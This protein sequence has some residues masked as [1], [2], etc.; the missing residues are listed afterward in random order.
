MGNPGTEAP[1]LGS[2][3]ASSSWR[4]AVGGERAHPLLYHLGPEVTWITSAQIPK[5]VRADHTAQVGTRRAQ[6]PR[7]GGRCLTGGK[8]LLRQILPLPSCPGPCRVDSHLR[9]HCSAHPLS[10]AADSQP[11]Q[12][13]C[14]GPTFALQT[15]VSC[16]SKM[17][18]KEPRELG[19]LRD[20]AVRQSI[21]HSDSQNFPQGVSSM[22][23]PYGGP[24][25]DLCYLLTVTLRRSSNDLCFIIKKMGDQRG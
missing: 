9:R 21:K 5:L 25:C 17:Q 14:A 1:A 20:L 6:G 18:L 10:P 2:C 8:Q 23:S 3:R 16:A 13:T 4:S 19:G 12:P 15:R 24:W 7:L 22:P 11:A